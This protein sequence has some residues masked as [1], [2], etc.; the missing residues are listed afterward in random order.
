[1]I[2]AG[3]AMPMNTSILQGQTG[4]SARPWIAVRGIYGGFPQQIL[5]R[6]ETPADMA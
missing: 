1:M 5:E 4:D 3:A 6:G 2:A